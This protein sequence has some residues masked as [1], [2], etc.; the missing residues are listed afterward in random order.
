MA[1]KAG[2]LMLLANHL[3]LSAQ[4]RCLCA[5]GDTVYFTA[6]TPNLYLYAGT[7]WKWHFPNGMPAVSSSQNPPVIYYTPGMDSVKL[8][9]TNIAG[10]DSI[11]YANYITVK[12]PSSATI[13]PVVCNIGYYTSPS[14]LYTWYSSGTY[15]DT[16]PNHAGCDSVLTIHLTIS[17]DS[18][19]DMY[20]EVCKSYTSPS[21]KYVWTVTGDYN[22]T[23]PNKTGCDSILYIDL[24]VDALDTSVTATLG[25]LYA[26]ATGVTYQW[27]NCNTGYSVIPNDT[28]ES[29]SPTVIGSYAVKISDGICTDIHPLVIW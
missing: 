13:S 2:L 19:N 14:G 1:T 24:T 12:K 8:V 9:V 16:I 11:T 17:N 18:Y 5:P 10:S 21:G 27:L 6:N 15:H 28:D 23:I 7:T 25:T 22:D 29:F 4:H 3:L 26:N 20:P